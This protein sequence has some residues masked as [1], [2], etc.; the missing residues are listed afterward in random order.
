MKIFWSLPSDVGCGKQTAITADSFGY[1][2]VLI[3][4]GRSSE[5]AWDLA[6]S[7]I[8]TTRQLKFLIALRPGVVQPS[9]AARMAVT[10]HRLSGGRL[11]VNLVT[12]GDADEPA[13]D[14]QFL[15]DFGR[16]K[17]AAEFMRHWR[18]AIGRSQ[19]DEA[20]DVE[21]EH[22]QMR[23]PK[24]LYPPLARP[25][26]PVFFGGSSDAA[27]D[28]AAQQADIYL[29]SGDPPVALAAKV[30][31]LRARAARHGRTLQFGIRL[32]VIVRETE[33][34]AWRAAGELVSQRD[35]TVAA[36]PSKVPRDSA[37][38]R[39]MTELHRGRSTAPM[40]ATGSRSPRIC[41]PAS[42]WCAAPAVLRWWAIRSKW[43]SA[44]ANTPTWA[45]STS[46][47]R[48]IRRSKKRAASPRWCSRC[49]R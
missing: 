39:R 20:V 21:A 48:V 13:S 5:D 1:E 18:E 12:G 26:P 24:R 28:L 34:A 11:L 6:A 42:R 44:C 22:P 40:C 7:L 2:G 19:E 25:D 16:C 43:P 30:A 49:F 32:H 36:V 9:P 29:A 15:S 33:D 8:D 46:F 41:G 38:P 37:G 4:T 3:P 14:G 23:G 35:E 17:Q 10:L 27:R 31:D 45:W 47:S